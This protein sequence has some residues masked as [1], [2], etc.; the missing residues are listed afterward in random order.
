MSK[1]TPQTRHNR[2]LRA[3]EIGSHTFCAHAWWL[4][5]V[6]GAQPDNVKQLEEGW[7]SHEHHGRQVTISRGLNRLA[8]LLLLLAALTG[9]IWLISS[10]AG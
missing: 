8:Y 2:V 9:A 7:A 1:K 3:S 5:S 10:F 4:G 6:Q